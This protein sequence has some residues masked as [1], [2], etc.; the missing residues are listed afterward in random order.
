[1]TYRTFNELKT[2]YFV[3]HPDEVD[4]FVEL[5]FEEY[6][7]DKDINCL[8]SSLESVREARNIAG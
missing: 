2:Q 8:I 1:M 3:D 5:A 7:K 4:S 6:K